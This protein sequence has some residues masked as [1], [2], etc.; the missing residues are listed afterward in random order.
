MK[1]S[2]YLTCDSEGESDH[3][4]T[5]A[6]P[7]KTSLADPAEVLPSGITS[8]VQKLA[9]SRNSCWF[10]CGRLTAPTKFTR[11]ESVNKWPGVSKTSTSCVCSGSRMISG[12][13]LG[14]DSVTTD[15]SYFLP[16]ADLYQDFCHIWLVLKQKE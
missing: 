2:N 13:I 4:E 10:G 11:N 12:R 14:L 3:T 7:G 9:R 8:A 15:G 6:V 5:V 1:P 16:S